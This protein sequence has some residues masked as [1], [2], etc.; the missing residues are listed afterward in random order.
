MS[1]SKT[2]KTVAVSFL[3]GSLLTGAFWLGVDN[4]TYFNPAKE[5]VSAKATTSQN[6]SIQ[7]ASLLEQKDTNVIA[8]MVD[9]AGPAVVKIETESVEKGT[10]SER[11]LFFRQFF[12]GDPFPQGQ[13]KKQS[14]GSG[15]IISKDGYIVTNNHVIEA[16]D[17]IKVNVTGTKEKYD[18]KVIGSDPELDLA[19][20][21][22]TAKED[23]P[24][25]KL[26]NSDLIRVGDWSVA[27]G[28]P[29]GL[30]HTVTVGVI[31]AKE[32]PLNI[33]EA[34]F[35]NLLQTDASIN[36]G[37][38]GGPLLNLQGEVIGINT[39]INAEAQGIGFAIPINTVQEVLDDLIHKGKVSRP[40]L[41]VSLQDL[42]PELQKYFGIDMSEGAVIG[43][44]ANGSPAE[45]AGFQQGDIVVEIDKQKVKSADQLVEMVGKSKV[46]EK[47]Q[48]LL[49]RNGKF[50]TVTVIIGEK[51]YNSKE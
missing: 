15:F 7:Q 17:T 37:N 10:M 6:T 51:N 13:Q 1:G 16:A 46:G 25:L 36:P 44:V 9:E 38:S 41:G 31:S 2:I 42:T 12:G 34:R 45:K 4:A 35:K 33:G 26:G 23:L 43:Y 29:Y 24:T 39:A 48:F 19:V 11:D 14:L 22:I 40:W 21:K 30:D 5:S 20:L 3:A 28:N 47:H 49:Y 18:A 27:I 50:E 8:K 32:R